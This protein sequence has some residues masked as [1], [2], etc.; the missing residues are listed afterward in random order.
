MADAAVILREEGV[1]LDWERFIRAARRHGVV[2]QVR[3][4]LRY[5]R[6]I[7][8]GEVPEEVAARLDS[9]PV[10][11]LERTVFKVRTSPPGIADG[12]V[13]LGFLWSSYGKGNVDSGFIR[14]LF[15]FPGFLTRVFGM[16]SVR[17]LAV[18]SGYELVRRTGK[19][20]KKPQ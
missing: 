17:H 20:L 10:S 7:L 19:L 2:L 13:E 14:R 8:P 5:L 16:G 3:E 18:Y 11:R 1:G 15:G 9:E 4:A 6:T 12:L